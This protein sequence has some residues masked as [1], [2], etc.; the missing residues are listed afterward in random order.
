MGELSAAVGKP[1][2]EVS[3]HLAQLR[4]TRLVRTRRQGI[5]TLVPATSD[6]GTGRP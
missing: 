1:A 3:Q 2:A 5:S 6:T 4:R